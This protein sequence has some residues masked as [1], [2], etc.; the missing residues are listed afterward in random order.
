MAGWQF[1]IDRGGTFT[2]IVARAPDGRLITSKILSEQVGRADDAAAV[3]IA[4][5]RGSDPAPIE[6]VRMGTTVATN[7]LLER[8]GSATLLLVGRGF[9]DL[10]EI[11]TQARPRLFDLAIVKPGVLAVC[12]VEIAGRLGADGVIVEPIDPAEV[13]AVLARAYGDGLRTVAIALIHA[14]AYPELEQQVAALAR[15]AGFSQISVS[16]EVA[17]V[18]R[19]VPRAETT[20]ADAY[21][22]PVL[23]HYVDQVA[24][25]LGD[26]PLFFMQ[27]HGGLVEAARFRGKDAVLS[28]PAGGIVGAVRTAE[29]AGFSHIIGFDMGGTS[30]DV[31][32]AAGGLSRGSGREVAGVRLCVP[33]LDIETVAAGG[34][35]I[36]SFDGLRLSVGPESAGAVP[37]P[38][39]Y[40]QGG[41]LTVT[42]ANL[43]LGKLVP[44]FFP[45]LFGP[46]GDQMLDRGEVARK[47]GDL[48]LRIEES[49]GIRQDPRAVAEGAVR[50]AVARMAQ[51]VRKVALARGHDPARFTL[52]SFGG[53]GGQHACLVA[54]EIGMETI[55]VPRLAGVLS[56]LGMGLAD[57]SVVKQ[58]ACDVALGDC[59][60]LAALVESLRG[61]A[62]EGLP[63]A[64]ALKVEVG[65]LARG[66]ELPLMVGFDG[67]EA[68]TA[69]FKSQ[70]RARYGYEYDETGLRASLVTVEAV[71]P[72][73]TIAIGSIPARIAPLH[74]DATVVWLD[75]CQSEV[76]L[77]RRDELRPGDR[78]GGPA[79][80][81]EDH[82][83]TMIE[84]GWSGEITGQD[85][86]ILRRVGMRQ[87][88]LDDAGRA[89]P[90]L[91][92]WFNNAFM[93]VAEEAGAILQAAARS[94]NIRERLDFSCALFDAEGR[95]MANAPHVP[96][97][98]GAMGESVRRVLASRGST[99]RPG[100]VVALNDP[101][102]GGTHLPDITV[103]TPVFDEAGALRFLL[104]ARGHHTDI[105]GTRPGS[106]PPFSRSLAEE[107]VVIT[108]FLLVE[109]GR[110]RETEFLAL[111]ADAPWPARDP[112]MNLADIKAQIAAN[113]A[114]SRA[115]ERLVAD[116]G[117]DRVARYAGFVMENA[118][119]SVRRL[120][121]RL[122]DG[123]ATL[124]LDNGGQIQVA[125]RLDRVSERIAIDFTG[126]S[127]ARPDNFNAP[128]QI[129]R[130]VVLYV[131]R[132]LVGEDIPLNEGCLVP[133]DLIV[134]QGSL[135]DPPAGSAVVAG[136]TE[137]SQA[138]ATSLLLALNA[139]AA[140][141]TTMNNL[142]FGNSLI[143]YYETICGGAGAG[144]GFEG[145]S[146][147]HTHMTNTR[148][149]D[150]E[151]LEWRL[152]VRLERFARR[153]GSGGRGKFPGGD[154]VERHLRFLAPMQLSLIASS[155]LVPPPGL[156]G[157]GPG[158]PGRQ[159]VVRADGTRQELPGIAAL[160]VYPGDLFVI[161]TP[162]GGGY[163]E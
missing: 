62:R 8:K 22:S 5:I 92:T 43:L 95:L 30:T 98:L 19:L 12:T 110:L 140:S 75:N 29:A 148:A 1:W 74:P 6:L 139:A 123:G 11:G 65:L 111:L 117:G 129:A 17:P 90:A 18:M 83:T 80:I 48:A 33:M 133:V 73:E 144:S 105:G 93:A 78:I 24:R 126:T 132:C 31:A 113:Q 130:S 108:D 163:G 23:R 138:L 115:L 146:A 119:A 107:G 34:G 157:G 76:P 21:L 135:I 99:L 38:A 15:E 56:A 37:G 14:W 47:F 137:I 32:L 103:I 41:P 116:Q 91:L 69:A 70:F 161:E 67:V 162:G 134:P 159:H 122:E 150:P 39:C 84:P 42:D 36:I 82:A 160:D 109:Q 71:L 102:A 60:A 52:V 79:V 143:Q 77:Y 26:V 152:P 131:L 125:V 85:Q 20:V 13:R 153:R 86:M 44:E 106:T 54:D 96:V 2:D 81:V 142:L 151:V 25:S 101:F 28:G 147:I 156:A 45:A 59:A 120:I 118:A 63:G 112:Q 27:S 40:R 10:L 124:P 55:L 97:H 155:R 64:T 51:S 72:G 4:A 158:L 121:G 68:M 57:Q 128:P 136:N 16:H 35:S 127:A 88:A 46:D 114:G 94:V 3:G 50:I 149:T 53:A 9:G 49:T 87:R 7:A 61:Q 89:D 100:D 141:Q 104:G 145:A 154:G 66:A 58:A